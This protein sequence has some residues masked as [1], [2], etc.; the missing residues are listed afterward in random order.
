MFDWPVSPSAP[1]RETQNALVFFVYKPT[2]FSFSLILRIYIGTRCQCFNVTR[3]YSN[4]YS[5][6]YH[7]LES[8]HTVTP[9]S[10]KS[11]YINRYRFA[12]SYKHSYFYPSTAWPHLVLRTYSLVQAKSLNSTQQED[13]QITTVIWDR[14]YFQAVFRLTKAESPP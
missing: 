5:W 8:Q 9:C 10:N 4:L 6:L 3:L 11:P 2:L 1:T 14:V 13:S 7:F 12:L